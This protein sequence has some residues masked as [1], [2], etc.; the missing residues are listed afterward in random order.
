MGVLS[1]IVLLLHPMFA[2]ILI[3]AMWWQYSWKN[4]NLEFKGKTR[5]EKIQHHQQFGEFLF[6]SGVMIVLIAFGAKA[7][8][9]YSRNEP[10]FVNL[11]PTNLHGFTGPVGLFLLYY[12]VRFGRKAAVLKE[13]GQSYTITKKQHGRAADVMMMLVFIHAFLGFIY[14]FD[15]LM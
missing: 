5:M 7:F 11:I 3:A 1:T 6:K 9:A 8:D 12:M 2:L 15:V 13:E 4:R 14:T 10:I